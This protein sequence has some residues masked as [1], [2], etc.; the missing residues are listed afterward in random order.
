MTKRSDS[1]KQT[2][3]EGREGG[4]KY[5]K[6]RSSRAYFQES[7]LGIMH[8]QHMTVEVIIAEKVF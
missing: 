6:R 7:A 8:C 2:S 4:E 3:S 5:R 1:Y